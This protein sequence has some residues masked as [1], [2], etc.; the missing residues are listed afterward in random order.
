[1]LHDAPCQGESNVASVHGRNGP[2]RAAGALGSSLPGAHAPSST[3]RAVGPEP[4]ARLGQGYR[5]TSQLQEAQGRCSHDPTTLARC[6]DSAT[7]AGHAAHAQV[8]KAPG[9]QLL[10]AEDRGR[11]PCREAEDDGNALSQGRDDPGCQSIIAGVAQYNPFD[12]ER[13]PTGGRATHKRPDG[14]ITWVTR[15][16]G[17]LLRSQRLA[18][19]S[20]CPNYAGRHVAIHQLRAELALQR[21]RHFSSRGSHDAGFVE[22]GYSEHSRQHASTDHPPGLSVSIGFSRLHRR[23]EV[24]GNDPAFPKRKDLFHWPSAW[25]PVS[26]V[27]LF[28][29]ACSSLK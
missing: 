12:G 2:A 6:A 10:L 27:Q 19:G 23:S 16:N 25:I 26:L 18:T 5:G 4:A 11:T 22:K 17:V 9:E 13:R 15:R 29:V 21:S 28:A 8:A 3:T 7:F 1:M 14:G 24:A 20:G